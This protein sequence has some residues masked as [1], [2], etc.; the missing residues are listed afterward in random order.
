[1]VVGLHMLHHFS[2]CQFMKGIAYVDELSIDKLP[3][4][5]MLASH[6]LPHDCLR[7]FLPSLDS[8]LNFHM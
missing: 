3:L 2:M 8:L 4:N 5:H 7:D 1:M 6:D